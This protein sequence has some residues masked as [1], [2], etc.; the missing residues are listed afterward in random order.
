V[1]VTV[2]F[3]GGPRDGKQ[4]GV[5]GDEPVAVL[6]VDGSGGSTGGRARPLEGRLRTLNGHFS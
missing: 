6:V 1:G 2:T 3:V 4:S 5:V